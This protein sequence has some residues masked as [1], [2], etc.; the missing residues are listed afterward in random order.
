MINHIAGATHLTGDSSTF[1]GA[2]HVTGGA[3]Y[4]DGKLGDATATLDIQAGG[5]LG[6]SGTFGHMITSVATGEIA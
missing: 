1:T 6:G 3:L 4:V 2:A 5:V